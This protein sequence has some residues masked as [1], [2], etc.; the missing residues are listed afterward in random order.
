[1][2]KADWKTHGAHTGGYFKCN[3]YE[4]EKAGK[5]NADWEGYTKVRH[6]ARP[7]AAFCC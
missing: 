1:M 3:I 7:P 4:K 6:L 2:C 5:T